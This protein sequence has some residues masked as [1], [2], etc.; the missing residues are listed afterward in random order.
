MSC[1]TIFFLDTFPPIGIL[2]IFPI[3]YVCRRVMKAPQYR[4]NSQ[5]FDIWVPCLSYNK[6]LSNWKLICNNSQTWLPVKRTVFSVKRQTDQKISH[7]EMDVSSVVYLLLKHRKQKCTLLCELYDIG[8]HWLPDRIG[9]GKSF[10]FLTG[11]LWT[12]C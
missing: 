8:H 9:Y 6:L 7:L 11:P 2:F 5:E 4:W 3:I 10:A 1:T 12:V